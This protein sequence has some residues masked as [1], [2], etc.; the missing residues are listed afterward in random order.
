MLAVEIGRI[1]HQAGIG[2]EIELEQRARVRLVELI[3]ANSSLQGDKG[4]HGL[5]SVLQREALI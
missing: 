4:K 3:R 2:A 5:A 1:F